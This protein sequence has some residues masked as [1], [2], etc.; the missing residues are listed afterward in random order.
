MLCLASA[1]HSS[2]WRSSLCF[3]ISQR[4]SLTQLSALAC[5]SRLDDRS[6][7]KGTRASVRELGSRN[8]M[9][10]KCSDVR[11]QGLFGIYRFR[12]SSSRANTRHRLSPQHVVSSSESSL[13]LCPPLSNNCTQC[14]T[15][16]RYVIGVSL[17]CLLS[18]ER[19]QSILA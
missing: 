4:L 5:L 9:D 6:Y 16:G 1:E 17:S 15:G 12:H 13:F 14:N 7:E 10:T 18:G 2:L 3:V 11:T 19:I 8:R